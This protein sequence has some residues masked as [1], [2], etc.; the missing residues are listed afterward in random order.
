MLTELEKFKVVRP[1]L[2][3]HRIDKFNMPVMF[4]TTEEMLDLDNATG[5][6]L[7][8][9]SCKYDNSK[10]IIFSFHYDS[11]LIKYWN[12]P[13][14]YIP[15][16]KTAMAVGTPDY[17]VLDNMN[18]NEI[19]HNVYMN[20]WLG[21]LWQDH[22]SIAMP[23]ISWAGPQTYEICFSGVEQNNVVMI[24]TLG[25]AEHLTEFYQGFD[26]MKKTLQPSLIIVY[27]KM[28]DGM[29]GRFINF[30]YENCFNDNKKTPSYKQEELFHIRPIFERKEKR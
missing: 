22:D 8:N 7:K 3:E 24:S 29:T 25:T 16:I 6:N 4:K 15:A 20:R 1:V 28:L 19:Q 12:D 18:P 11:E 26:A 2:G 13:F 10:K 30:E 17:S 9:L 5:L 27:G 21:C 14:K 23:T